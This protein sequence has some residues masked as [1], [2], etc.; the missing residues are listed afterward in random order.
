MATGGGAGG[1]A[2]WSARRG[3]GRAGHVSASAV[4][5]CGYW[6]QVVVS[7]AAPAPTLLPHLTTSASTVRPD[8]GVRGRGLA[9]VNDL[10]IARR[11]SS[12]SVFDD[13][14]WWWGGWLGLPVP[15][16][17]ER[18]ADIRV[19]IRRRIFDLESSGR[20]DSSCGCWALVSMLFYLTHWLLVM[21][22]C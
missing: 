12:S 20:I 4:Q 21:A 14:R 3:V 13:D 9:G 7:A 2:A 19:R 17:H 11:I 10:G 8:A 22:C 1:W 18:M 15:T 5:P 16:G 6:V